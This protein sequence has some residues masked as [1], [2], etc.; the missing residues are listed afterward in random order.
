[1]EAADKHLDDEE[2]ITY[3]LAEHDF[4]YKPFVEAFTAKTKPQTLNDLYS[5]LLT[6][7]ACVQAQKEQQ[8]ISANAAFHGDKGG[9]SPMCICG[10]GGFHGGF[11]GGRSA[12]RGDGCGNDNKI[13]CQVYGKTGHTTLCC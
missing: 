4:E 10:D 8:Q 11:R 7:E 12:G 5:Q 2:V 3:I 6:T 9:H 13:L 1:M